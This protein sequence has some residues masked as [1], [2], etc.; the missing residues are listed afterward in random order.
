[1][2]KSGENWSAPEII[3]SGLTIV[4]FGIVK[5]IK[6]VETIKSGK[7]KMSLPPKRHLNNGEIGFV[8]K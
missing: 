5:A 7:S 2:Y 3:D 4:T 1:M 6:T 8:K